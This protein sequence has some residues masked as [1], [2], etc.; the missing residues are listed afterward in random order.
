MEQHETEPNLSGA[1]Y[2]YYQHDDG[3]GGLPYTP[4]HLS[5]P[6]LPNPQ[7]PDMLQMRQLNL[8][9]HHNA[10]FQYPTS[11]TQVA[12]EMRLP[13]SPSPVESSSVYDH[14]ISPPNC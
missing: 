14:P 7:T 6:V 4:Q 13:P 9:N 10:S 2:A 8:L 1:Q 11:P 3:Y 5:Y 12:S